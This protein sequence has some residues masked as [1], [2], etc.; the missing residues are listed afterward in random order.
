MKQTAQAEY[1][2]RDAEVKLSQANDEHYGANQPLC[3]HQTMGVTIQFYR[4]EVEKAQK[5]LEAARTILSRETALAKGKPWT[6]AFVDA[7]MC[8]RCGGGEAGRCE[9]QLRAV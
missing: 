1:T 7:G 8:C 9:S 5:Q 2:L 4:E 3:N 6:I